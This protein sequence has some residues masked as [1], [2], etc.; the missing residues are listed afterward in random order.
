MH[1]RVWLGRGE[2]ALTIVS[3]GPIR[4]ATLACGL[5]FAVAT[6]TAA[7]TDPIP[8][9][10]VIVN[11]ANPLDR[12]TREELLDIY[13]GRRSHFPTG[14]PALPLDLDADS[15]LRATYYQTLTGKTVAQ[16]NAY[17]A[18]LIF[19]GRATP[20]RVLPDAAAALEAVRGNR[21]AIAY[22]DARSLPSQVKIVFQL[23]APP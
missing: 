8:E 1:L 5:A 11:A 2:T 6:T 15:P 10:L 18:R 21:H 14:D 17:W 12:L 9:L 4:A 22:I 7:P 19:T 3:I 16:I 20:P 23:P 13:M